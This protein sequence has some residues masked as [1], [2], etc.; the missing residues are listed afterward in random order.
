MEAG[1][2]LAP[3]EFVENTDGDGRLLLSDVRHQHRVERF[4]VLEPSQ[5]D[6]VF[7]HTGRFL[8]SSH[9]QV[10]VGVERGLETSTYSETVRS[11]L[12]KIN[13]N[14]KTKKIKSFQL[15]KMEWNG[16]LLPLF[17]RL[18]GSGQ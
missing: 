1:Q 4:T 12:N 3:H 13:R 7:G 14:Y 10:R 6:V 9:F 2:R 16:N 15:L 5:E 11:R 18:F 8:G 17:T